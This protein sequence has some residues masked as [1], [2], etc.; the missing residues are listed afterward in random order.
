MWTT[1]D[2]STREIEYVHS[3]IKALGHMPTTKTARPLADNVIPMLRLM[4]I[5]CLSIASSKYMS[6]TMRK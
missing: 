6:L 2:A 4:T 5:G 1:Q 3:A